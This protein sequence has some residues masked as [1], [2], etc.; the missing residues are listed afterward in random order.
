MYESLRVPNPVAV[1]QILAVIPLKNV[2]ESLFSFFWLWP[3]LFLLFGQK[4][5]LLVQLTIDGVFVH[6]L[7]DKDNCF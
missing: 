7:I 5:Q 4:L 2:H 3:K 6:D 1:Y